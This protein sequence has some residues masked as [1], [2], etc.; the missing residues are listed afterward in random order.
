MTAGAIAI[1]LSTLLAK[2][3][4]NIPKE[5]EAKLSIVKIERK[6]NNRPGV[7]LRPHNRYMMVPAKHGKKADKGASATNFEKK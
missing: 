1:A 4:T 6:L 2:L 3:P 5:L 7:L